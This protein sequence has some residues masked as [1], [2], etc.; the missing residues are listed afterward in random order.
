MTTGLTVAELEQILHQA[1]PAALLVPP[2]IL[3]R[4]IKQD[5]HLGGLGLQVPHRKSYTLDR[6]ALLRLADRSELGLA[7]DRELPAVVL[8]FPLPDP[9]RLAARSRADILLESWRL[10]FHAHVH[11]AM[12]R[13]R[14]EGKLTDAAVDERIARIG[15][16]EF[17]EVCAVLRQ[18]HLLLAHDQA[19]V[20]E[21]FAAVYLELRFFAPDRLGMYFPA[22]ADFEAVDRALA[23]HVDASAI[24]AATRLAGAPE[25][26]GAACPD[27][28]VAHET[29]TP[30]HPAEPREQGTP[31]DDPPVGALKSEADQATRQGNLVAAALHLQRVA[32]H[33]PPAERQA[34]LDAA[35]G[36]IERLL[37][38]LG[39]ALQLPARELDAWRE[40]LFAV[41]ERAATEFYPVE[42][43]FLY[44]LQNVCIDRQRDVYAVDLVEWIVSWGHRP[45]KRLLPNQPLILAVKHLHTALHR[46]TGVRIAEPLR[47]GLVRLM[48]AAVHRG[49]QQVRERF[50]PVILQ[51]L[52][53]VGLKAENYAERVSRDK[54]VD[55][56]LDRIVERRFLGMGDLRDAIARNQLKLPDLAGP[57]EFLVGDKLI[58]AN[59]QFADDLDGVYRRGEIYLR[60]LQRLS[61]A[62][63]GTHVGRF[64]VLYLV[65]PF[66][67][68]FL[69]LEG[70]HHVVELFHKREGPQARIASTW[71]SLA[72]PDLGPLLAASAVVAQ[73]HDS[74]H[75]VNRYSVAGLGLFLFA[76]L[77][78]PW[79]RRGV[80][81]AVI[82]TWQGLVLVFHDWPLEFLRLPWVRR[83]L[84]STTYLFIYQYALK[85]LPWA[86]GMAL[87]CHLLGL[88]LKYSLSAVAGVFLLASVL[89]NS[90]L[91]QHVEEICTD[92]AVRTWNLFSRDVVPGLFRLVMSLFKRL[93]E[94]VERVLYAVDVLLRFRTGDSRFSLIWK[95]TLGLAWF[96]VTYLIRLFINL[97]VE[98][99]FNP[100]KHFPVVTVTAKLIVPIIKPLTETV[101][102]LLTPL[103]IPA[104][105][106]YTVAGS[107]IFFLPGLAG[108][109]VW[110]LKENWRL[111]RSNR[112]ATLDPVVVGSHGE[113]VA[114]LLRPGLHSGTVPKIYARLR[115]AWG[116]AA[117]KQ[118]EALHHVRDSLRHFV[119]RDLLAVLAGSLR[120]NGAPIEV[121]DIR[122]GTNRIRFELRCPTFGGES[123]CLD[124]EE[125][126]GRLMAGITFL[127]GGVAESWLSHMKTAQT[128]ALQ[129]ALAGFCKLAGVDMLADRRP[130]GE[131]PVTWSA[132][133][134]TWE[135]DLAGKAPQ[136]LLVGASL[137]PI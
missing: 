128:S 43:R 75:L 73:R 132:W 104:A 49:E 121:A 5:R 45:I 27:E 113:T 36:E 94:D 76:L 42:A 83:V 62:A 136:A 114:R 131:A 20:Y 81:R 25:P 84:D 47:L 91:G 96:F 130:F 122:L 106:A 23:E 8:L 119:E 116:A 87:I 86:A 70:L 39:A 74:L 124:F 65:L 72:A 52:E 10:L 54:L 46:L 26:V 13:R 78:V 21:E 77:H 51:A 115:R 4:V 93:L 105:L 40:P 57:R 17:D 44:D 6:D 126:T 123:V 9:A 79:F 85:P 15:A 60:W 63:F 127:R 3:R 37:A 29:A 7:A 125:R 111:Y 12:A 103:G 22:I 18:E 133:V 120:W 14:A 56:L 64:L 107:V 92:R 67:G 28:P 59:R 112:S 109:L 110:E 50:R 98:P 99:T 118:H 55:E 101:V 32:Q 117:H 53:K 33:V 30:G 108:F 41:L 102:D 71:G 58:R 48:N 80:T 97:F 11:L 31:S 89:V 24:Y 134:Q 35:H 137:L 82:R 68:A 16:T 88:E 95:P 129:D 2:R 19:A 1:E 69:S 34:A 135:L 66:G 61:S 38:Q 100:I 90:R